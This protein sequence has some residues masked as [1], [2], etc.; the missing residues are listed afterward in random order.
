MNALDRIADD[1]Y[2]Q[3]FSVIDSFLPIDDYKD[4]LL[5]VQTMH[6]NGLFQIAKIGRKFQAIENSNIRSDKIAWLDH[7]SNNKA[8]ES[9][10]SRT[11]QIA[12]ILNKSFFLG[13]NDFEA[14]FSVYLPGTFYRKHVDQFKSTQD[15]RISC[16]YY[17]NEGW[18]ENDGGQ[19]K[20]YDYAHQP[21]IHL[22]PLGNRFVCFKS[23]LAHEVCETHQTR[24]SIAGWM[25]IRSLSLIA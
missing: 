16:V 15:R 20:L 13:L 9:Y 1:I 18:Q 21:L 25:K 4:L 24:Y 7:S 5:T 11:N 2:H 22:L 17:L 19:L 12:S 14:H 6:S 23:D 8:I 10:F 3:G